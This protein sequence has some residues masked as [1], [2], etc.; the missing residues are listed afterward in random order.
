MSRTNL[1]DQFNPDQRKAFTPKIVKRNTFRFTRDG[2][3]VIRLHGT[4]I[5]TIHADKSVTLRDGGWKTPTTKDRMNDHMPANTR[6]WQDKGQWFVWRKNENKGIAVKVP[7]FDGIRVP[8]CFDKPSAKGAAIEKKE[9]KLRA[10]IRKFVARCDK[11]E[12]LPAPCAGDC[13][14]CQMH[15]DKGESLGDATKN[16]DHIL[17]HLK[18]G[19][20][21]GSLIF[22]ALKWVGYPNPGLIWQMDNSDMARGRKP[23]MV[24]RALKRYL[25]RQ[26]GLVS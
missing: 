8:Q 15:T 17:L 1:S 10:S 26:C 4:D 18:E 14:Y 2:E 9:L 23:A 11:M 16:N 24:K 22:N 25:Y 21:H 6:L 13:F 5:V 19:Y 7:Y 20:L 3:T 12:T